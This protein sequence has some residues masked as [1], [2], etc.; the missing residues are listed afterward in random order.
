M[1]DLFNVKNMRASPSWP[2]QRPDQLVRRLSHPQLY[3]LHLASH[4]RLK[5]SSMGWWPENHPRWG[6]IEPVKISAPETIRSLWRMGLLDG[7]P[8]AHILGQGG[9]VTFT[10]E[11]WANERG[12]EVLDCIRRETGIFFDPSTD[13]PIYRDEDVAD[14]GGITVR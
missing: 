14:Y 12:K 10:P 7:T 11:L 9:I 4:Y 1:D 6:V 8:D 3:N 2:S 13:C 5:R